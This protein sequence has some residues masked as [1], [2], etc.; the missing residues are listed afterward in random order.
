[1]SRK[2]T[3]LPLAMA[4]ESPLV[5]G[6]WFHNKERTLLHWWK[7]FKY[8]MGTLYLSGVSISMERNIFPAQSY[9]MK[10]MKRFW[11]IPGI[12]KIRKKLRLGASRLFLAPVSGLL[13][14]L[15]ISPQQELRSDLNSLQQVLLER[16]MCLWFW[17]PY[18][19]LVAFLVWT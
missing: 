19:D 6:I 14:H 11:I 13:G 2:K 12:R 17:S 18:Y 9:V 15:W 8:Q 10:H 5:W 1:M 3:L 7:W 16:K 4:S